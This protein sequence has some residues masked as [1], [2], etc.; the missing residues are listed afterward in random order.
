MLLCGFLLKLNL[1]YLKILSTALWSKCR[2]TS[3]VCS[4][5]H[6]YSYST[7]RSVCIR[8]RY[9][10]VQV[11]PTVGVVAVLVIV[12][13][14]VTTV[15]PISDVISILAEV[16]LSIVVM[17]TKDIIIVNNMVDKWLIS[18][19]VKDCIFSLIKRTARTII[20]VRTAVM[21]PKGIRTLLKWSNCL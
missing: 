12:D 7:G 18:N 16:T 17:F 9:S 19:V 13:G 1:A 10:N 21:M 2:Y 4:H 5:S 8:R 20:A 6:S 15:E 3:A 11:L 14:G